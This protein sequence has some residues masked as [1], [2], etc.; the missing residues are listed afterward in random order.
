MLGK[1]AVLNGNLFSNNPIVEASISFLEGGMENLFE[2]KYDVSKKEYV[3][4]RFSQIERPF[5]EK[6][7]S[8]CVKIS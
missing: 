6:C 2:V 8:T 1:G 4:E 3:Y 5:Y 7:K